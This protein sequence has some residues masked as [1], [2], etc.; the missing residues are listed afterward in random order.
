MPDELRRLDALLTT[1]LGLARKAPSG[2]LLLARIADSIELGWIPR[3]WGDEIAAELEA[4]QAAG[5]E[6]LDGRAVERILRDAWGTG[7][8]DE[9]DDLAPNP[10]AVTPG[11]QVHRGSLDGKPVAVKVVRPGLAASVRQDMAL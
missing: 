1:G 9:L 5:S 11:P 10:V 4:A 7:P 8:E 2:R 3:P 6:P